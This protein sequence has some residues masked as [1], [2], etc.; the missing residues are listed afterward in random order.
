MLLTLA[1]ANFHRSVSGAAINIT[2]LRVLKAFCP[3]DVTDGAAAPRSHGMDG[4]EESPRSYQ[5]FP[6]CSL[7]SSE[8]GVSGGGEVFAA[9]TW[10]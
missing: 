9:R 1:L 8:F 2:H 6:G 5:M 7:A 3:S 4:E 10:R